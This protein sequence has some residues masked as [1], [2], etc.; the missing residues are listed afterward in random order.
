MGEK[1]RPSA[2]APMKPMAVRIPAELRQRL[3]VYVAKADVKIQGVITD[4][5][6]DYLKKHGG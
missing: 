3:R 2:P 5:I 1:K 4:A 6:E